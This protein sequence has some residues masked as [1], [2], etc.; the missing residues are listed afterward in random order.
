MRQKIKQTI[1]IDYESEDVQ[2]YDHLIQELIK[3]IYQISSG[4]KV[5]LEKEIS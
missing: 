2:I 3:S 1:V 4:S 5:K